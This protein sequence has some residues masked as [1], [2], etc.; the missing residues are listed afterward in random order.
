MKLLTAFIG[1]CLSFILMLPLHEAQGKDGVRSG[2]ESAAPDVQTD[3]HHAAAGTGDGGP[4]ATGI[5]SSSVGSTSNTGTS[6]LPAG[7]SR[8]FLSDL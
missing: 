8:E 2:G 1:I 3:L 4:V 7:P 6:R 5:A